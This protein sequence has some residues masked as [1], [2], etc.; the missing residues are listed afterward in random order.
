MLGQMSFGQLQQLR[1]R[2]HVEK[3]HRIGPSGTSANAL[4]V[5]L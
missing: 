4:S 5:L 1:T 2:Q 3:F